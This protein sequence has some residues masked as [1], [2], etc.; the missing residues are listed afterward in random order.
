L[1]QSGKRV[2]V[3]DADL[4]K[5]RCHH[6]VNLESQDGLA[7][8]LTGGLDLKRGIQE[9]EIQ[10][11]YLLPRGALTPN[12]ADLLMSQKMRDILN[13]LRSSFDFVVI[14]SPPIIAVSD[15]AVLSALCDGVVLVLNGQKT[16]S[17]SARRALERLDKVGAR[18]L[19]VVLNGIDIRDP[20]YM[21]YR[22]YYPSYYA[23]VREESRLRPN[24]LN[25]QT[26]AMDD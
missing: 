11:F 7:N 12:P 21:D 1:A 5:G 23:S 26:A 25:Y 24:G 13:E 3:I 14:D 22:S 15:A 9:T 16:T 8:V 17:A 6:L 19:G 10:D 2:L 4:R 18:T 20:E